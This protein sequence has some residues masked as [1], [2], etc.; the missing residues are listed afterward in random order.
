LIGGRAGFWSTVS[1][2]LRGASVELLIPPELSAAASG[3]LSSSAPGRG[4]EAAGGGIGRVADGASGMSSGFCCAAAARASDNV[5]PRISSTLIFVDIPESSIFYLYYL[6]FLYSFFFTLS[7]LSATTLL[8]ACVFSTYN[9]GSRRFF[10]NS[11]AQSPLFA[12]S[13]R[14]SPLQDRLAKFRNKNAD[15]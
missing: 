10:I 9:G 11:D 15:A 2:A 7:L 6:F 4:L 13:N 14:Y 8:R 5:K 1:G 3:A 12:A